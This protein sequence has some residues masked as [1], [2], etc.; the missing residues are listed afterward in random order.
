MT[1]VGIIGFGTVG[2]GTARI[3]LEKRGLIRDRA[4]VDIHLKRI[5]DLD[6]ET[7]RGVDIPASIL[8]SDAY[9]IIQDTEIDVVV[10]LIGG[11]HPA[12]DFM[13]QALKQ[14]KHVVTANKALLAEEGEELFREAKRQGK[15]LGFE[16]AVA[17]GIPIIKAL[18]EGL[19][20]NTI[21]ALYGI[22]NGTS[23]YILSRMTDEQIDFDNALGEAQRL[24]YAEA[25]P[26]FDV[27]GYDAAH[28]LTLLSTLAYGIP[29]SYNR[30]YR[31]GITKIT[32]QDILFARELG[33]KIKP[34]A[35]AKA[36]DNR[37]ELRVH[38][39]MIPESYLISKVEGVFNAVYVVGDAV[40]ETLFYGKGAGDMPTGSA[41]VSDIIDIARR[42]SGI[43][44]QMNNPN[45]YEVRDMKDI[46]SMYY[47]RFTA[48]D[49]PGV[50]STVSGVLG[51]HNISISG[52]IQKERRI[53]EAVPV[54][55]LTHKAK[56]QDV[57]DALHKIDMLSVVAERTMVLR[58]EG[59]K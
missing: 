19:A 8:T 10:E 17:G 34:L 59:E 36:V 31:E 12:R 49:R 42:D 57:L 23:N 2:S 7:D 15:T 5:A 53:G 52:V 11:I 41:V 20:A 16:A 44:L 1:N 51:D 56:E 38:P 30:V 4:G 43:D 6:T 32:S 29:L 47:F 50:L 18:R 25:D 3:L 40:G 26:T 48:F 45:A 27:E 39:T 54:V 9:G 46:E 55:V 28:K 13:L 21:T 58:V 33:Y 22:I 35:I 24:G 37:V 14:G